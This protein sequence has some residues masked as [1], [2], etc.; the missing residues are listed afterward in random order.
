KVVPRLPIP[1]RT[2]K[3]LSAD[4]SGR[5]SV[6]VGHRQAL[7]PQNPSGYTPLGFCFCCVQRAS[8]LI[9]ARAIGENEVLVEL[10][11]PTSCRKFSRSPSRNPVSPYANSRT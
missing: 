7:I 2:V 11:R 9:E 4:D 6:K 8:T 3:R 1:N 10:R 5:T